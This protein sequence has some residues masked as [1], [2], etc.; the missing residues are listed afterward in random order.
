MKRTNEFPFLFEYEILSFQTRFLSLDPQTPSVTF[1]YR[2]FAGLV[3]IAIE[4]MSVGDVI[5]RKV[6]SVFEA[7]DI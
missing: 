1:S 5:E 3:G 4:I 2:N 6:K 7:E